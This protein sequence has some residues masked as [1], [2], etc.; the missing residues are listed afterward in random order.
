MTSIILINKLHQSLSNQL[1]LPKFHSL[2]EQQHKASEVVAIFVVFSYL[3][4][5]LAQKCLRIEFPES[6]AATQY[7]RYLAQVYSCLHVD[8]FESWL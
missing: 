2:V 1:Q 7:S 4:A 6:Y 8:T 5:V 3:K